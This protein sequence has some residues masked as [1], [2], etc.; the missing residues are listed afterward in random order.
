MN[1]DKYLLITAIILSTVLLPFAGAA[2]GN[3]SISAEVTSASIP[4]EGKDTLVVRLTWEGEPFLYQVDDFPMP[5]LEKFKILGSSSSVASSADSAVPAGQA[6]MR[7]YKYVLEPTDFGTGI[8]KRLNL[9]AVNRLTEEKHDLQTGGLTVEIARPKPKPG[10]ES[11]SLGIII[12]IAAAVIVIVGAAAIVIIR[13]RKSGAGK[14]PDTGRRYLEALE[15]IKKE[16]VADGKLFYSRLYRLL[17]QY[18]E[19]ECGAKLSGCTG[20]E[21]LQEVALLDNESEKEKLS[22]WLDKAL[23]VKFRPEAPSSGEIEDSYNAVHRFFES[24]IS[25]K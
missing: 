9:I 25:T 1:T 16:T 8:I 4:F 13:K 21:V 3:I 10:G 18:L 15:E 23:K 17:V 22:G 20:E 2:A 12:I 5:E 24:R 14:Q 6:T 7:T 19:K 11:G